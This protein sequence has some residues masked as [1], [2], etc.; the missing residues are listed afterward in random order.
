[1]HPTGVP[2]AM[3]ARRAMRLGAAMVPL[4][5]GGATAAP[6]AKAREYPLYCAGI[7]VG[8]STDR[9][10]RRMYG[11]GLYVP[12]EGHGGGRYFVDP[13]RRVTL[14]VELGVDDVIDEVSYSRGILVPTRYRKSGRVPSKAISPRL[15]P[16]EHLYLGIGLGERASYVIQQFGKPRKDTRGRSTRVLRY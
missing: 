13:H 2:K 4:A 7:V 12:G 10:V 3:D 8:M 6:R 14:H 16:N 11:S 5:S 1:M 9:D 15:T